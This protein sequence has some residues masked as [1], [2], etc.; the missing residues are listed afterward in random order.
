MDPPTQSTTT[1]TATN[2]SSTEDKLSSRPITEEDIHKLREELEQS[3]QE[4]EQ[5]TVAQM[6]LISQLE[7]IKGSILSLEKEESMGKLAIQQAEI[8]RL[9]K[10]MQDPG[11]KEIDEEIITITPER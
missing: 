5:L 1:T 8:I 6:Q 7:K 2:S 4:E 10:K 11:N 9:R 3:L